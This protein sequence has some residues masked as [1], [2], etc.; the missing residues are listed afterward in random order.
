MFN[1]SK[2]SIYG[3]NAIIDLAENY[4]NGLVQIKNIATRK[5]I[6]QNYL[7]QIL[8]KLVKAGLVKSVRGINGGYSLQNP[9]DQISV[10]SVLEGEIN[11]CGNLAEKNALSAL[12]TEAENKIKE[13][14]SITLKSLLERQVK[15][16]RQIT[17]YI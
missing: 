17:Y 2:K 6:P 9:P 15:F 12:F 4:D 7:V 1:I 13:E 10:L 3:I 11:L 8:N 5:N 14:L 16:N